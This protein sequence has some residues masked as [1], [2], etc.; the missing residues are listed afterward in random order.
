[1][2]VL[3]WI[4]RIYIGVIILWAIST[5]FGG[6][7]PPLSTWFYWLTWPVWK[8]FGWAQVGMLNLGGVIALVLLF[9]LE[10]W[11]KRQLGGVK[12]GEPPTL[13]GD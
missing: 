8:L 6:F 1:M 3:L 5:W 13:E 2:R 7:P 11:L 12:R 10:E 4:V 9:A